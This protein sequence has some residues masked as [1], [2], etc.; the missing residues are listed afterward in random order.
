MT[1]H[2]EKNNRQ[3]FNEGFHNYKLEWTQ[4]FIKFYVD[5]QLVGDVNNNGGKIINYF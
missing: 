1:A 5:N 4:N 3:G 2:Y